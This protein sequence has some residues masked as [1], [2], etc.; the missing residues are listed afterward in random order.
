[1]KFSKFRKFAKIFP[2]KFPEK[3]PENQ[4]DFYGKTQW[5]SAK[6]YLFIFMKVWIFGE[7]LRKI[8]GKIS[9][10]SKIPERNFSGKFPGNSGGFFRWNAMLQSKNLFFMVVKCRK[11]GENSGRNFRKISQIPKIRENFPWKFPENSRKIPGKSG[12]FLG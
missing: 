9:E 1:M 3:F 4:A 5:N 11:I 10:M 12:C 6:I 2:G 8:S 7:N